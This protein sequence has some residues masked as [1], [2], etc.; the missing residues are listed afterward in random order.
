[1]TT[2]ELLNALARE[3]PNGVSFD[4]MALRLLRQQVPFEDAQIE[5]LK[6]G[7]FQRVDGRWFSREMIS[8]VETQR[9]LRKQATD[10]L[11]ERCCFSVERL[12]QRFCGG[13]HHIDTP[14]D[15]T[16]FLRH[17]GFT[18]LDARG[19]GGF[20]CV[21]GDRTTKLAELDGVAREF[22][23]LAERLQDVGGILVLHEIEV[24]MPHL[25]A[26]ALDSLRA[27]FLPDVHL[28]EIGGV[29]CWRS[30]EAIPLPED[31][32]EKLTTAVDTLVALKKKVSIAN[33]EFALNLFYCIRFREEYALLDNRAFMGV[34]KKHYQG[35]KDAFPNTKNPRQRVR[36]TN[37]RFRN[38]GVPIG[39]EL[40]FTRD[41]Q[42]TC[43]VLDDSN[44]VAR[45]GKA[46]TLSALA[47]H[48]L[49]SNVNGFG[50]FNYEGETLWDRRLRLDRDGKGNE[51]QTDR[52][53]P[54][55]EVMEQG[56]GIIG[57]D[58]RVL[59]PGSWLERRRAG[60]SRGVAELTRRVEE[61]ESVENIASEKGLKVS[62][63][64]SC[65]T[66][67]RRYLAICEINGIVP[68]GDMNV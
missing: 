54:P 37:T 31:F 6:A 14:E 9:A 33:L 16:T 46:W 59:S 7:M 44:Q 58:G 45:D 29:P 38:L 62:I 12:L 8:N 60:T 25:T 53:P 1:M 67:R 50:Y 51:N 61:G 20:L 63:V 48:L 30:A 34:C 68:E 23:E 35:G 28:A 17:L 49:N 3:C 56:S 26:E 4:P 57:L 11:M 24:A 47:N 5:D 21:E 52:M 41:S 42:I 40:V 10:W 43:T 27:Q 15:C 65:I 22:A 19:K 13:L 18:V 2:A 66:S 36:R 32:A 64:K 55:I 39:A